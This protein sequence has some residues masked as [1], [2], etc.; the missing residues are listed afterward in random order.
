ML[1]MVGADAA[2]ALKTAIGQHKYYFQFHGSM[3]G[4]ESIYSELTASDGTMD[5]SYELFARFFDRDYEAQ[6]SAA[7]NGGE[8]DHVTLGWGRNSENPRG[9]FD[10]GKMDR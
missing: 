7:K 4:A 3:L 1:D 5:R 10:D 9:G 6:A 2:R 8:L